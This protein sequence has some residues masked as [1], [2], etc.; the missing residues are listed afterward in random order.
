MRARTLP[1]RTLSAI[2]CEISTA[3]DYAHRRGIVH[4]DVKPEN[5]LIEDEHAVIADFGVA[6]ALD[7]A[8]AESLT[9]TGFAVGTPAYMSP[10]E[11]SGSGDSGRPR[12]CLC[13]GLRPLRDA[14]RRA[15]LRGHAQSRRLHRNPEFQRL[16]TQ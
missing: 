14:G 3:L 4:R 2:T 1:S 16:T 10:E 5:I 6:R 11:A 13:P 8:G 12:R 15:T 7:M 9:G